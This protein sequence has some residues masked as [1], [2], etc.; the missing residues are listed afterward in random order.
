M[1]GN[2]HG[3]QNI[4]AAAQRCEAW[5]KDRSLPFWAEH[6]VSDEGGFYERLDLGGDGVRGVESRVRVQARQ[7]FCFALAGSLGWRPDVAGELVAFGVNVLTEQCRRDDGLYGRMVRLGSGLSDDAVELY[8]C[9]FVLLAYATAWKAFRNDAAL[10]AGKRLTAA[11]DAQLAR[12][13]DEG[14]YKERL[15]APQRR[16]QNPHMHLCE[17]SLA[18]FEATGDASAL[19]RADRLAAFVRHVFFD[20]PRGLLKEFSGPDSENHIE[21]GHY[22]EWVWILEKLDRLS[23]RAPAPFILE[24]YNAGE[25]LSSGHAVIPLSQHLDG[26]VKDPRQ[27]TWIVTELLKAHLAIARAFP[28]A[29]AS[30]AVVGAVDCLFRDHLCEGAPQGAW[31]DARAADGAPAVKDITAATGYHVYLAMADLMSTAARSAA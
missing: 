11:I 30:G 31:I 18:W 4:A 5:L 12:P 16:E 8:D 1:S 10:A 27:R 15:P 7:T 23:G 3:A 26:S 9:A 20:A 29:G 6:G 13:S 2:S 25:K 22:Y 14:G 17:A 21:V 28:D 19:A 24:L